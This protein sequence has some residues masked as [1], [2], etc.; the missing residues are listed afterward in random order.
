LERRFERTRRLEDLEEAIR[1]AEQAVAATLDDHPNLVGRPNN[2]GNKLT[3]W[4]EQ[5]G[6]LKDLE[7]AI[8]RAEQ[9]VAATPDHPGLAK[10]QNRLEE[11]QESIRQ[12][13][14]AR[15]RK[16]GDDHPYSEAGQ[17]QATLQLTEHV[18]EVE[19]QK[20]G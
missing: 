13:E 12:A 4:F 6:R 16:L 9:A 7:K 14:Q 15:K 2:L 17:W 3:R 11:L 19:K 18:V 8:R 5:S 20:L 10:R 1:Q